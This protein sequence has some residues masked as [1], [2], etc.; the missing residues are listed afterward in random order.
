MIERFRAAG[1]KILSEELGIRGYD[2][3]FDD[4]LQEGVIAAWLATQVPR[5]NP[6]TYGKVAMRRRMVDLIANPTKR[7]FYGALRNKGKEYD[8]H[9]RQGRAS[10]EVAELSPATDVFDALDL[11]PDVTEALLA[12]DGNDR[13]IAVGI[14]LGHTYAELGNDLG[15]YSW[16]IERRWEEF[17]RPR[18]REALDSLSVSW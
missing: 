14:A 16:T 7:K 3:R 13:I 6:Y 1:A 11:T 17:I 5:D 4:L 12:L 10:M 15:E 18:L 9:G 2:E 8:M